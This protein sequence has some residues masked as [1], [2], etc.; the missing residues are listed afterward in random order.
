MLALL[1]VA[2]EVYKHYVQ[3]EDGEGISVNLSQYKK[4]DLPEQAECVKEILAQMSFVCSKDKTNLINIATR[5][6]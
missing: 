5:C 3:S 4:P 1:Q 2:S 6:D